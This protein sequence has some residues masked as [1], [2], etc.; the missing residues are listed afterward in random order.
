MNVAWLLL[1]ALVV[2][3]L[4]LAIRDGV[5]DYKRAVGGDGGEDQ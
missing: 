1:A 3:G 2:A 4:W 5:A